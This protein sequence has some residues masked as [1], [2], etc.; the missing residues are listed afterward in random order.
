MLTVFDADTNLPAPQC[1]IQ[2]Y[3]KDG[4]YLQQLPR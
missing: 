2:L 1:A 3:A 4:V